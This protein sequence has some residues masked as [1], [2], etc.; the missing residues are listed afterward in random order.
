MHVDFVQSKHRSHLMKPSAKSTKVFMLVAIQNITLSFSLYF[1]LAPSL[2]LYPS[3]V[4]LFKGW[5]HRTSSC[6]SCLYL[7]SSN[8][9]PMGFS[10]KTADFPGVIPL[11]EFVRNLQ[12]NTRGSPYS[13]PK[14]AGQKGQNRPLLCVGNNEWVSYTPL[15]P[16]LCKM[17]SRRTPG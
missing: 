2:A 13:F 6:E 7:G 16:P 5:F 4:M 8:Q 17:K 11:G 3:Q 15:K 9:L 10:K 12:N 14:T 1:S